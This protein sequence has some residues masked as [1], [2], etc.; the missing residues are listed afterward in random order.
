MSALEIC[1]LQ[2]KPNISPSDPS[3]VKSLIE[4][5]SS[6]RSK[7]TNTNSQ[8]YQCIED[9]TLIYILGVWPTISAHHD[10]LSSTQKSEI[11]L[12]QEDL[13]DFNWVMHMPL[14]GMESLPLD[15]PVMCI[16]RFFVKE[17]VHDELQRV[18]D[19]HRHKIVEGSKPYKMI[20]GWRCDAKPGKE[21]AFVFSGWKSKQAHEEFT[22]KAMEDPDYASAKDLCDG[23][24]VKHVLNM[25]T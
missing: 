2:V 16:A 12:P 14:P 20:D 7:V 3:V 15:A 1:R 24:E 25:E 21:E 13:L 18:L 11:L 6:L 9:P 19:R 4:V 8:F 23:V 10:F 5:R 22:A 17:G